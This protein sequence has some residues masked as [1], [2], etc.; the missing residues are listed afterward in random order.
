M[1]GIEEV[2]LQIMSISDI[3]PEERY[4]LDETNVRYEGCVAWVQSYDLRR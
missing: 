1:E 4:T 3:I 2:D